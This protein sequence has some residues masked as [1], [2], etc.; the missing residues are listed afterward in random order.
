MQIGKN[1]GPTSIDWFYA[2]KK[3][4]SRKKLLYRIKFEEKKLFKV[5]SG[6]GQ[7]NVILFSGSR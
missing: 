2:K 7:K 1:S 6:Q 5:K 4:C 3:L